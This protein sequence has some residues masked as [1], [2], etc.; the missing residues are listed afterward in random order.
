MD[1]QAPATAQGGP[2]ARRVAWPVQSGV[3]PPLANGFSLRPETAPAVGRM[4]A[5]R[6]PVVLTCGSQHAE[7]PRGPRRTCG[8]TQLAVFAAQSLWQARQLDLLA[9]VN[10]ATRASVL[11]GYVDAARAVLGTGLTGTAESVSARFL[12]WLSQTSRAW[13]VVLDGL[14][15]P[16]VLDGLWPE[17]SEGTVLITTEH[18]AAS[19]SDRRARVIAVP[20]LSTRESLNYLMGILSADTD[21]RLGAMS[22]A[23]DLGG[24]PLALAQAAAVI[25]G[26]ELTCL[27]YRDLYARKRAQF[28]SANGRDLPASAVTW[29]LC[30]DQADRLSADAAARLLLVLAALLGSQGIPGTVF[31]T[32]AVY[33]YLAGA[34][35]GSR[36]AAD[37]DRAR[38][39]LLVL[40]RTGLLT[41]D[42][43]GTG[44]IVWLSRALQ[45]AVQAALPATIRDPAARA[46]ADALLEVWSDDE[47][48]SWLAGALRSC[49]ASLIQASGD[50]LWADGCHQL[51]WRAGQSL[52]IAGLTGPAVA[53]WKDITAVSERVLGSD[54]PDTV[55]AAGHLADAYMAAGQAPEAALWFEWILVLR[56]SALGQ[57]H[58]DTIAA[59]R[60]LGHA[61]VAAGR[62]A[63]AITILDQAAAGYERVSGADDL[64][65]IGVREDIAA[66]LAAAARF[67][68]ASSLYRRT[69]GDRER[70]QGARHPD[71][72]ATRHKLADA[73][74]AAGRHRDARNQYRR[75]L[76]DRE[77]TLGRGHPATIAALSGLGSAHY[78]RGRMADALQLY[79]EAVVGY[80]RALGPE[81]RDTLATRTSLATVYWR[82]GRVTDAVTL[83]RDT[84]VR[85]ERVLP[86]EDPLTQ[87]ARESLENIAGE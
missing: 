80:E 39:A 74:L 10:A 13:L 87:T 79:E 12:S 5:S 50:S 53:Y 8:K 42:P 56:V 31:I 68:D 78:A 24:E 33:K 29:T 3:M 37:R 60:N 18:P 7:G 11:S 64:D 36:A 21:Q 28:S 55:M 63:D 40:E 84:V 44:S 70:I 16:E 83:L 59:R 14:S 32:T 81:H 75:L 34:T 47:P 62:L 2:R 51:L 35:A 25:G 57:D 49:A 17:G 52:G 43:P 38:D 76:A 67:A 65:T 48:Q 77:H 41:L 20:P 66:A 26:S 73:S 82:V 1:S 27:G 22:L 72:L 69:L 30:L 61:L 9:W 19:F 23:Q 15:G 4:L 86:D 45:S 54:H 6:V 46:A 71:T 58:A 85:C